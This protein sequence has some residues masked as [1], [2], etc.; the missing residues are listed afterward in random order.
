MTGYAMFPK[1]ALEVSAASVAFGGKPV[2]NDV[3]FELDY[4]GLVGLIGPNGAGKTTLL[5]SVLGEVPL[6]SGAIR[7]DGHD[8]MKVGPGHLRPGSIGYVPQHI[9]ID[10]ELPLRARDFVALGLDGHRFG[11]APRGRAFWGR[12]EDALRGVGADSFA[13]RPVGKLSGGQQQ[14]VMIAAATVSDPALLLLDEPLANLDPAN[15][16]DVVA[17]LDRLRRQKKMGIIL[18]AHDVN[19]L[20]GVLDRVVYLARGHAAVG[21]V[22]EVISTDVLTR[23]YDHPIEVIRHD[24]HVLVMSS[25]ASD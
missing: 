24:G 9:D 13:E 6:A 1:P 2:F 25:D 10:P 22:D 17:L 23:L 5:R 11:F 12:V 16:S 18:T 4:G 20:V 19:P 3:S 7:I 8:H 21:S 14:R 15:R